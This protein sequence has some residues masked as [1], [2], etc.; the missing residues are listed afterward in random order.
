MIAPLTLCAERPESTGATVPQDEGYLA[1]ILVGDGAKDIPVGTLV[2]IVVDDKD[3]VRTEKR[4]CK[5]STP[6]IPADASPFSRRSEWWLSL[7]FP[8]LRMNRNKAGGS[9]QQWRPW[10][11]PLLTEWACTRRSARL[12]T[13]QRS[14]VAV[15][16]A[17]M[18]A[19]VTMAPQRL[20]PA[21][22]RPTRC[23]A[24]RAAQRL[25]SDA[26]SCR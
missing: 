12:V 17:A 20:L 22:Q 14:P 10:L 23:G 6:A 24:A 16:T 1:K 5:Q 21:M 13:I 11:E 18:V 3:D 19:A 26:G 7:L 25:Y 9:E 2:A 4:P 15:V 8:P